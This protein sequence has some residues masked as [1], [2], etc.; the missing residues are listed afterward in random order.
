MKIILIVLVVLAGVVLFSVQNAKPVMVAFLFWN[1]E[2][3]LAMVI[4][5]SVV[6]GAFMAGIV[7]VWRTI[8]TKGKIGKD[9]Q[10]VIKG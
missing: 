8:K 2:A 4:L 5:T 10:G 6:A 1:F 7:A 9:P 3:S